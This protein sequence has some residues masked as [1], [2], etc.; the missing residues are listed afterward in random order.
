M[1]IPL[2]QP[3][4]RRWPLAVVGLLAW[5]LAAAGPATAHPGHLDPSFG[6]DG[7][8]TTAFAGDAGANAAVVQDGGGPACFGGVAAPTAAVVQDGKVVAAG[9]GTVGSTVNFALA[10]YNRD[11]TLDRTFGTGGRVTTGFGNAA[12]ATA[13]V[14]QADGKLVAAGIA[15]T[16]AGEH[17][18]LA[19][20]RRDGTLDSTF[21][22]GGKVTTD[23][24]EGDAGAHAL[25]VQA[26]GKLVAAGFVNSGT[27]ADFA[28]ARY[29]QNG[30]LDP[31][32]GT[33]GKVVTDMGGA[34]DS[35][36][37]L[38]VQDGR[39][40]AAG[41]TFTGDIP[42]GNFALARYRP[43][44]TLDPTFGTGG[45]VV[46]DIAG[47]FDEAH[48]LVV[49]DGKL[50]AGG[51]AFTGTTADFALARYRHDGT[52]DPSF[53]TGGKVTTDVSAG[54]LGGDDLVNALVV[55]DGKLVAA[56]FAF[57]GTFDFALARYRDNG[58]LD[59]TFGDGGKVTTDFARGEDRAEGLV[60]QGDRLVAAGS[61]IGVSG[62]QRFALAR[63]R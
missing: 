27:A 51:T 40:V 16:D 18:A 11:G 56:G 14:V 36:H 19:R 41:I 8:V 31:T 26:D 54:A 13:L 22:V 47:A 28:L 29:R 9:F 43:N 59:P 15:F 46:T 49:Q 21:G 32:F 60:V 17:F 10:R 5:Q 37:A 6:G 50:V 45:R 57:P 1:R 3:R 53:G 24:A 7:K 63:Y 25:V 58:A 55:Q 52:L 62:G 30:T 35:A 61:T 20:Y 38:V 39:P 12:Q 44:G 33:G 4:A 23:F 42:S 2:R 34:F 48:A